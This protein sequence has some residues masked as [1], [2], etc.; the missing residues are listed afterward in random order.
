MKLPASSAIERA[1]HA[2]G[3]F[4]G[5]GGFGS[6]GIFALEALDAARGIHEFLLAREEG[7]AVGANL[8]AQHLAFDG[9]TGLKRITT[10][11]VH[12]DFVVVGMNAG[13]HRFLS[14]TDLRDQ[15]PKAGHVAR[16]AG[17]YQVTRN[18]GV[19]ART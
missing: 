6:L 14:R 13:F 19:E 18:S 16:S 10:G 2:Q 12:G 7:M 9:G 5:L 4:L 17:K 3:L 1:F 11:T 8:H 15:C